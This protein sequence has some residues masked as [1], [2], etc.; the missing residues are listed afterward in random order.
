MNEPIELEEMLETLIFLF[1]VGEISWRVGPH[2]DLWGTG[3]Q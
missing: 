3:R 1:I 2:S